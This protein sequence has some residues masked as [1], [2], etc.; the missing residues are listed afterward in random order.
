MEAGDQGTLKL[1]FWR[2]MRGSVERMDQ[3]LN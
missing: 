2:E 3:G 1:L